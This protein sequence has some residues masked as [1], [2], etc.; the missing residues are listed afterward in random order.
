VHWLRKN[1]VPSTSGGFDRQVLRFK[2]RRTKW[3]KK[4][5]L[6]E[7]VAL[8]WAYDQLSKKNRKHL[9]FLSTAIRMKVK[10]KRVLLTH[11]GTALQ[12]KPIDADTSKK[13]LQQVATEAKADMIA[14]GRSHIALL[15]QAGGVLFV[16]PGSV[17][18]PY[19]GD[20]RASYA[21]LQFGSEAVQVHH[22]RVDYDLEQ[23]V[24][25]IRDS[26]L[27]EAIAQMFLQGRELDTIKRMLAK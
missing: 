24:A 21:L 17:G 18:L 25:A 27:P 20:P 7:Y 13:C 26:D 23:T 14:C 8:A 19:D 11:A 5:D 6:E 1:S 3:R 15:R 2:K 12:K 9:R 16:N 4:K 22:H 10:G